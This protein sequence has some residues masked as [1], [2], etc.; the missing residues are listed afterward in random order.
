MIFKW[1]LSSCDFIEAYKLVKTTDDTS[2]SDTNTN[3]VKINNIATVKDL[4]GSDVKLK[5]VKDEHI[6]NPNLHFMGIL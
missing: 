4:N 2:S 1:T 6:F 3:E 5:L